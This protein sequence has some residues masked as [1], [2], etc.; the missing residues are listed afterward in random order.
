[1][2]LLFGET[3]LEHKVMLDGN[4]GQS[5]ALRGWEQGVVQRAFYHFGNDDCTKRVY[6]QLS[7]LH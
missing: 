7:T 4:K 2:I 5:G 1:M 3:Q 6:I